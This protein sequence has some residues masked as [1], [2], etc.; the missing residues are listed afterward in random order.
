MLLAALVAVA[1]SARSP[2]VPTAGSPCGDDEALLLG[3][4]VSAQ[5]ADAYC[6]AGA[7]FIHG[8]CAFRP[9]ETAH[10]L[11]VTTG[12][13]VP[14]RVLREVAAVDGAAIFNGE[15]LECE[16][17]KAPV[18][19][20]GHV[21]CVVG[22]GA[23]PRGTKSAGAKGA[24]CDVAP[25]CGPGELYDERGS[26]C[27][28]VRVRGDDGRRSTVDVGAWLRLAVGSDG[29]DG[30]R[31]FCQP[32]ALHAA[33]VGLKPGDP[34]DATVAVELR[35][36]DDDVHA[37]YATVDG[38]SNETGERLSET[39]RARLDASTRPL[40]AALRALGGEATATAAT[41][42]VRCSVRAGAR[43]APIHLDAPA[44]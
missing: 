36:P 43:P 19:D 16:D 24:G 23:C 37:A 27:V 13:C 29:G 35:V 12:E 15:A 6:G 9:C 39:A 26:L 21:A 20:G 44:R 30:A 28:A 1:C 18:V 22:D 2:L 32:L 34:L 31:A 8:A 33:E 5:T 25:V 14:M 41:V 11:D 7:R 3:A 40:V 38:V 17:G 4:C 42:H 10:A